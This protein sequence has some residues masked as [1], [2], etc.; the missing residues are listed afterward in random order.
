MPKMNILR[1]YLINY[2]ILKNS[3]LLFD[4]NEDELSWKESHGIQ[5]IGIE[6]SQ[7]N[8]I[9]VQSKVLKI[10]ENYITE[11]HERPNRLE[12]PELF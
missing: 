10:W 3:A 12:T 2:G 11:I 5:N 7:G 9:V 4:I 1:T 6:N 8:R